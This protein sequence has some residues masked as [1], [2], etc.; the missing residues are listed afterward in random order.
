MTQAALF[1]DGPPPPC[2][3]EFNLARYVLAAGQ[4]TPDKTALDCIGADGAVTERLTY[5]DLRRAVLGTATGL[6]DRGIGRGDKVVLRLGNSS[7]FPVVFLAAAALGAIPVPTAAALT[8]REF[9]TLLT[10]LKDPRLVVL[11][12]DLTAPASPVPVL[13]Q[14]DLAPMRTLPASAFAPTRA[15]DPAYIIFTSGSSG[16]PKGVVHAHRAV[17]ARRMMWTGWYGLLPADRLLHAGAFNWT[18]TLGTGLMDPWAIGATALI[19]SGPP[20]PDVWPRLAELGQPTLFAAAPGVFRQIT[21]R[22]GGAAFRDLR[23]ALAAGEPLAA[24]TRHAWQTQSGR[25]IFEALGMSEISTYVSSGPDTPPRDGFAGRPQSG[26]SVAVLGGAGQPVLRN[27]DGILAVHRR[28]PGLMLG[29]HNADGPPALPLTGDW[30]LTGDRVQMVDDGYITFRGRVDDL[31]NAGGFR[32]SPL[33]IEAALAAY[34]EIDDVA[35][36]AVSPKPDTTIIAALYVSAAPVAE[37]RLADYVTR[38]LAR[39]KQPRSLVRV[40][41][42]PRRAN[43]KLDRSALPHLWKALLR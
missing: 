24:A 31:M 38:N 30:F 43:G 17:W 37:P 27:M 36:C 28:D 11:G 2:P 41:T 6:A 9:S 34:P 10:V 42:L 22:N 23:H 8:E 5:A 20:D 15:D 33:E 25:P 16:T 29:Y 18:F 14:S 39:H 19:Y 7:D 1:D 32:V 4:S 13:A 21:N 3:A 12:D 40:D 35:V 26:R